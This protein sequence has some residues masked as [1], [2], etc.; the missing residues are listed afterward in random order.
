MELQRRA[1]SLQVKALH[2]CETCC[3]RRNSFAHGLEDTHRHIMWRFLEAMI[4]KLEFKTDELS[5]DEANARAA[6]WRID[7]VSSNVRRRTDP[8]ETPRG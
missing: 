4:A 5:V 6:E 8:K 3:Y 7:S 2:K 1:Q